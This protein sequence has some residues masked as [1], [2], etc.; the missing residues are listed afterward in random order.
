MAR[1]RGCGRGLCK[2]ANN[3]LNRRPYFSL[4]DRRQQGLRLVN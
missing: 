3:A 4:F 1:V 2:N